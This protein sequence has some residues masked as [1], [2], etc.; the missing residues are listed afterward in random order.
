MNRF[1]AHIIAFLLVF[2]AIPAQAVNKTLTHTFASTPMT[3]EN[4]N[5]VGRSTTSPIVYTCGGSADFGAS[6]AVDGYTS[7]LSI[8]L[9][10]T[11]DYVIISPAL[12]QLSKLTINFIPSDKTRSNLKVYLSE[13]GS[14]WGTALAGD[15]ISYTANGKVVADFETGVY[16]V[17][18]VNNN[19]SN[20]VSIKSIEYRFDDCNCFTYT[21]EE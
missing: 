10:N 17:K 21:P 1:T 13:D 3:F 8:R 2:C 14:E 18:I 9:L 12:K 4:D 20:D 5:K 15:D 7:P 16:Y 6:H 11:G 19:G